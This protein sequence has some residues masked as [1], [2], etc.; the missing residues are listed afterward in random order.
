MIDETEQ[1]R[2]ARVSELN[3]GLT[4]NKDARQAE[5]EVQYGR[6]WD[7]DAL[8]QDFEV[9]SFLAPYVIAREK[10]TGKMGSLEF[11]H[12]P[13]LYFNWREDS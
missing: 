2:R 13:R 3:F 10:A 11:V 7:T 4:E 5:L 6:V 12:S 1:L 8:R 9:L